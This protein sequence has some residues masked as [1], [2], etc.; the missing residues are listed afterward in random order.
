MSRS[1]LPPG[2][3]QG[4]GEGKGERRMGPPCGGGISDLGALKTKVNSENKRRK[5]TFPGFPVT[6]RAPKRGSAR[7]LRG[8]GIRVGTARHTTEHVANIKY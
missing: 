7:S 4:R 2:S 1:S 5:H 8:T 6:E 3:G